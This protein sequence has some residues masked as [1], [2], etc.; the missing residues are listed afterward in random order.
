MIHSLEFVL[1]LIAMALLFLYVL[2]IT[3]GNC[4]DKD[5]DC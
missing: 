4:E 1:I 2:S 5:D 3:F